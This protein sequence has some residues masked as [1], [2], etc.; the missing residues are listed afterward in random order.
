MS[1]CYFFVV[2]IAFIGSQF[3]SLVLFFLWNKFRKLFQVILRLKCTWLRSYLLAFVSHFI[4]GNVFL[5]FF[6]V[7]IFVSSYYFAVCFS[8]SKYSIKYCS[9]P[10]L[11]FFISKL[12]ELKKSRIQRWK[13]Q[14]TF[15]TNEKRVEKHQRER[16]WMERERKKEQKKTQ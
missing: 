1:I 14:K 15:F 11:F 2:R 10:F 3:F 6:I 5:F 9:V 12:R 4:P 13:K 7:S 8:T 16:M